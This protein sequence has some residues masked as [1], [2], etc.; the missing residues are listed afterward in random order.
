MKMKIIKK[1]KLFKFTDGIIQNEQNHYGE[2]VITY[3]REDNIYYIS[4]VD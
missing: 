4:T 3:D 2:L 1:I